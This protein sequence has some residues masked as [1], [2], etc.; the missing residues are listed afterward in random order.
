MHQVLRPLDLVWSDLIREKIFQLGII[1]KFLLIIGLFPII[2]EDWFVPFIVNWFENPLYIPWSSHLAKGGD[3]LAFPYGLIMFISHLPTT[4]IGWI[5]DNLFAT[6]YFS[7]FGFRLSLFFA[8]VFLLILLLQVFEKHWSKVL[9]YYWLSP[10][11]IFITYWHGQTD[12]IPVALFVYSL[13]LIKRGNFWLAGIILAFSIGAKHSMIIGAPFIFLYLWSHNGINKELQSFLIYFI[14]SLFVIE[15]PF[16]I[17]EGFRMMVLGNREVAKIYWL[18]IEMGDRTYLYLTPLIYVLLLYFFWRIRRIN[19]DLLLAVMGVAFS[20]I[21]IMTPSPPGW[22]LWLVPIFTLHQSRYGYGAIAIIGVFSIMFISYHLIHTSGSSSFSYFPDLFDYFN[23]FNDPKLKSLHF[24]LMVSSGLLIAIQILR[25]GVRE[26]DYYRLGSKP[27]VIGISGDSGV[28]KSTFSKGLATVFG[29]QS[30]AEIT[31]DDYHNWERSSPMWRT[32]THLDPKA[33]RLF[34]LV[35]D[36]RGL[37]SG[38]VVRARRYDHKSGR[39]MLQEINKSRDVILVEGLHTLY[40]RQL[41][42]ELDVSFFIEM[43]ESLRSHL[44]I[45]RDTKERGHHKDKVINELKKRKLDSEKYIKPQAERA[46]V[47]FNLLLINEELFIKDQ[48]VDSN[49]KLRVYIKNGIY[50]Q[51][52]VRVLIGVCGLQVNIESVD[53]RGEVILEISGDVAAEDVSLALSMLTPHAEELLDFSTEFSDGING[54]MQII[55]VIEIDEALK[56][57]R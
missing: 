39:F 47:V 27:L 57:R 21:I 43:D 46:D 38:E 40:P 55:T 33:N 29:E 5:V 24:T 45:K 3:P 20:V 22:Y 56:R 31:G 26:N 4:F 49:I 37:I 51:E 9:I 12:L 23:F 25:E 48:I 13:T 10:L 30:L 36:V 28:G 44:R 52:L 54:I 50:Y 2:Q 41:L 1:I 6:N 35:K 42:E 32:L 16:L 7:H 17:T 19:F 8:D 53:E 18:F 15:A 14:G 11:V 34:E